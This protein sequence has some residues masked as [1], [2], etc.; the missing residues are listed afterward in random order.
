MK[1]LYLTLALLMCFTSQIHAKSYAIQLAASKSPQL[2]TFAHLEKF[3][4][5]YI[6]DAG[7]G[8]VRTRLGP[9]S[10]KKTALDALG[11]VHAAGHPTAILTKADSDT[12]MATGNSASSSTTHSVYSS[13]KWNSL[14]AEQ[15]SNTVIL[16]GVLHLKNGNEFTPL[17]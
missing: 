7:N 10:D 4:T 5:L 16:D 2:E 11:K 8:L 15:Q 17:Y 6:T 3:G 14:T 12:G 9:F 13:H 1:K